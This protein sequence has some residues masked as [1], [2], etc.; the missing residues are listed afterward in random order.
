MGSKRPSML[1]NLQ[2]QQIKN[3]RNK[4][5]DIAI[6]QKSST[7]LNIQGI[8]IYIHEMFDDLFICDRLALVQYFQKVRPCN[9][10]GQERLHKALTSG[11]E[12]FHIYRKVVRENFHRATLLF[13]SK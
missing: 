11:K 3:T 5:I 4:Y 8:H 9:S 10:W 13:E 1:F 2:L 12:S 7:V 6:L